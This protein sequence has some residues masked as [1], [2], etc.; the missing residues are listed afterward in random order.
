MYLRCFISI[1]IPEQIR[2]DI[3]E[4]IAIL[5]KYN[6]DVKW[7]VHQNIHL[8]LKFLGK[9]LKDLVPEIGE[10]LSKIVLSYKTFCIKIYGV[11]VFPNKR[12]PRVLWVGMEDLDILRKLQSDIDNAMT[13]LGYQREERDFHPHLT[14]GRVRSQTGM[15]RLIYELDTFQS[16][17]FGSI[18]VCNV[19]LMQS[20]LRPTGARY[21]C[22]QEIPLGRGKNEQ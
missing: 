15:S 3:G 8:T 19:R 21:S 1:D 5:R 11:G 6:G 22:L 2:R 12:Y 17:D 18:E 10:V 14:I 9:T 16:K 13:S 4:L 7:V 20:E